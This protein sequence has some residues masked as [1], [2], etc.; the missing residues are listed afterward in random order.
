MQDH[1]QLE[2]WQRAMPYVVEIY[3]FVALLPA[4][5]RYNLAAQLRKAATSERDRIA[6]MTHGLIGRLTLPPD[7]R[8]E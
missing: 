6:R 4:A 1:H 5:E 2:I 8:H 3:R 7:L